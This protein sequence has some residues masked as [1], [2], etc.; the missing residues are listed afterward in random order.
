MHGSNAIVHYPYFLKNQIDRQQSE[1]AI[2]FLFPV[3]F[4]VFVA[5][6]SGKFRSFVECCWFD[7]SGLIQT[8]NNSNFEIGEAANNYQNFFYLNLFL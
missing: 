1:Y 5:T 8:Q 6:F 7:N 3:L 4:G 2:Y